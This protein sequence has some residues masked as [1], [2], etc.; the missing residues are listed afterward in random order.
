LTGTLP[1]SSGINGHT[2][3]VTQHSSPNGSNDCLLLDRLRHSVDRLVA[4]TMKIVSSPS[5]TSLISLSIAGSCS[6]A[7]VIAT[8]AARGHPGLQELWQRCAIYR[9]S[10]VWWLYALFLALAL[11]VMAAVVYGAVHGKVGPSNPLEFFH[12]PWLIFT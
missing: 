1:F 10:I 6:V 5:P 7:G 3:G 4:L 11:N 2:Y 8:F 12:E 9:V